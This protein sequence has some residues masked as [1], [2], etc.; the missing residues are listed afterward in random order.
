M[1][2]DLNTLVPE[3]KA[4]VEELLTNCANAGYPMQP[5]FAIRTPLDQGK[6]WRQSRTTDVV[7]QKITDLRDQ[8]ADFLADCIANAGPQNGEHVT[9][10]IPGISWHQFGEAVDCV[11]ILNGKANWSTDLL[12]NGKNGYAVYAQQAK[13]L[14]LTPGGLWTS[15]K[16]WPHVQLRSANGPLG[17]MT[18]QQINDTMKARFGS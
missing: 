7:Q 11:W 5:T 15:F 3:F 1:A 2:I 14:G 9:N 12:Y 6:L 10:A 18:L 17:A 4:K 8:G 16:D 13:A